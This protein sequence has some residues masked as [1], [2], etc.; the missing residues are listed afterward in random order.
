M[1]VS[2]ILSNLSNC[3]QNCR[4]VDPKERSNGCNGDSAGQFVG[5][6]RLKKTLR[7]WDFEASSRMDDREIV[8]LIRGYCRYEWNY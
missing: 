5:S 7:S 3:R 2:S 1:A 6:Q 8:K 4:K